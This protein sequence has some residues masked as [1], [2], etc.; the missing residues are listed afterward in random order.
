MNEMSIEILYLN[1]FI[2]HII[3]SKVDYLIK[4]MHKSQGMAQ[5]FL[6]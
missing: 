3:S 4:T 6:S 5:I 1:R 2:I